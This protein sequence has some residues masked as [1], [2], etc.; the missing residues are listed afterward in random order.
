MGLRNLQRQPVLLRV[1]P[2]TPSSRVVIP[3]QW[4]RGP[5][6]DGRRQGTWVRSCPASLVK[7]ELN[8]SLS[9]SLTFLDLHTNKT[10][11]LARLLFPLFE[12]ALVNRL[13]SSPNHPL[14]SKKRFCCRAGVACI[15][16]YTQYSLPPPAAS[17]AHATRTHNAHTLSHTHAAYDRQV[18]YVCINRRGRFPCKVASKQPRAQ[19]ITTPHRPLEPRVR[20]RDG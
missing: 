19:T 2:N 20:G 11:S 1:D 8:L 9:L 6:D 13:F 10:R 15:P 3:S 16:T 7:P 18:Y 14:P 5:R 17:L 12:T 4:F